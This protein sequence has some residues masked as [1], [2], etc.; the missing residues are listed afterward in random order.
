MSQTQENSSTGET[1]PP[2]GET[3]PA[4][5]AASARPAAGGGADDDPNAADWTRL[6]E[7]VRE[8]VSG[9]LGGHVGEHHKPPG[10]REGEA[11]PGD[12]TPK[13]QGPGFLAKTFFGEKK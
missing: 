6:R 7:V 11:P 5:D 4:G 13:S 8:E 1:P 2:A 10:E 9:V 12:R 3:P